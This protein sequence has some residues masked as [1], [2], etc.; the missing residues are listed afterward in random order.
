MTQLILEHT[1]IPVPRAC[2]AFR[3]K[4]LTYIVMKRICGKMVGNAYK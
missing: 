2:S 3:P 4:E 1:S